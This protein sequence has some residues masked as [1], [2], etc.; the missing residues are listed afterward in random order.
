M[1]H[2][3]ATRFDRAAEQLAG[4]LEETEQSIGIAES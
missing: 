4:L 2:D 1:M 3:T